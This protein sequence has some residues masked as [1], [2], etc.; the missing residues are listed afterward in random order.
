M[1]YLNIIISVILFVVVLR[2]DVN[3][4]FKKWQN[5]IAVNHFKEGVIRSLLLIPST[6]LLLF[7]VFGM[8]M[9]QIVGKLSVALGLEFAVWWELFD[10]LYNKKRGKPWRF[11]GS[12][13]K[14]DSILDRFLYKIG[15]RWE[16]VLKLGLI[17]TS[18]VLYI[19]I[20][21]RQFNNN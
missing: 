6:L 7:P 4:D 9:W 13:D 1:I 16:G 3:S 20:L 8:S 2:W 17:T 10:G 11:N 15:D 21:I 12:V 18:L 14:D 5:E 19:I